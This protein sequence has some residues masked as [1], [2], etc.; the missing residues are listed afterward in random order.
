MS[1]ALLLFFT[2][3]E[4]VMTAKAPIPGIASHTLTVAASEYSI[5]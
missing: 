5:F 2:G 4:L 3:K 1:I